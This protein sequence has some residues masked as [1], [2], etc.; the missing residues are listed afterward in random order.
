MFLVITTL[1]Q[2]MYETRSN[3]LSKDPWWKNLAANLVRGVCT[4]RLA[5][6]A[7]ESDFERLCTARAYDL[8]ERPKSSAYKFSDQK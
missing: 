7:S 3:I 8:D 2:Y 5:A 1:N 6:Q 4:R